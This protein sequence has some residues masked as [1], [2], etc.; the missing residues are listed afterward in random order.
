MNVSWTVL[1]LLK[2]LTPA[3]INSCLRNSSIGC[4][5]RAKEALKDLHCCDKSIE[6]SDQL[7]V[8]TLG[9]QEGAFE[10]VRMTFTG[11]Q[12]TQIRQLVSQQVIRRVAMCALASPHGKRQHLAVSHEKGKITLL[13]LA[14]LLK[15]ADSSKKKLTLTRLASAPLPFTAIS[16]AGNPCNEDYLA[17][18]GLKDCNVLS[19]SQ[20]G[21]VNG[22]LV[23]H[24]QLESL[25]Y[26]IK[27]VWLPGSQTELAIVTADFVKIYDLGHDILSPQYYFLLPSGKL[28]DITFVFTDDGQRHALIMSSNGHIYCQEMCE[29]SGAHNGPFYVTTLLDIR[30]D[31]IES[32]ENVN[33]GGIS[34]YYSHTF[35]L[36][37][38]SYAQGKNYCAA[39]PRVVQE[40]NYLF[41]IEIIS[42]SNGSASSNGSSSKSPSTSSSMQ[43][44]CQWTEVSG[45]PGLILAMSLTSNNPIVLMIKPDSIVVQEIKLSTKSKIT[46][47][48]A[49][50][51]STQ[52]GDMRTTLILLC[53]DGIVK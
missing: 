36:L 10:N 34:I 21:H 20:S 53:E 13:Q 35:Q 50:R 23:L 44:L 1:S 18:C 52:N 38:F 4:S 5:I 12:G 8:P 7:M 47:M 32:N 22:H 28:R 51:H 16:I 33:G 49:I 15:Q 17:V 48:V 41:P 37:F 39:L 30:H 26:V 25:N 19:F 3:M 6:T 24:L 31:E 2:Y 46:D 11:E 45:H 42:S 40:I 14:T 27:A 9:S 29:E 43:S